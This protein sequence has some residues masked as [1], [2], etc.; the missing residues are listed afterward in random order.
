MSYQEA[1]RDDPAG[2]AAVMGAVDRRW[3]PAEVAWVVEIESRWHPEATNMLSDAT[4]LIQFLPSTARRLGTTTD[5]LRRMSRREQ[6]PF[7]GRYF[8]SV[9]GR[10]TMVGDTYLAVFAPAHVGHADQE[11][12]YAEPSLGWRQNP[13]LREGREGPITCQS[14]RRRGTPPVGWGPPPVSRETASRFPWLIVL[15]ALVFASA[16]R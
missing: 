5:A 7:V 1:L 12:I 11:V 14:V 9:H 13:G 2:V 3:N 8:A 16:R 15:A 10:P 6:A 4:G